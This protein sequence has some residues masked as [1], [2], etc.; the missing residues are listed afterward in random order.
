MREM[1][2]PA[3]LLIHGTAGNRS[4]IATVFATSCHA[5]ADLRDDVSVITY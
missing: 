1:H 4:V 3:D 5:Q 2:Q